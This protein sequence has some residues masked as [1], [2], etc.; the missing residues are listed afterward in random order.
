LSGTTEVCSEHVVPVDEDTTNK[1]AHETFHH[2]GLERELID[3]QNR[4]GV[5][6]APDNVPLVSP[7]VH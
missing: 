6:W 2:A 4:S 3:Q 7:Q 1:P 5:V